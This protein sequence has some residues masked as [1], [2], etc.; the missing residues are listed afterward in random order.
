MISV[1]D[2]LVMDAETLSPFLEGSPNLIDRILRSF[3][4]YN[5]KIG[6]L[7]SRFPHQHYLE[8]TN[9]S[10]WQWASQEKHLIF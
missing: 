1:T 3:I 4:D 2:R 5:Q 8:I 7:Q 10:D 6:R 9:P